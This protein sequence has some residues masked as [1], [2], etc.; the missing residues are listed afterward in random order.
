[1]PLVADRLRGRHARVPGVADCPVAAAALLV[2]MTITEDMQDAILKVPADAWT[3]AYDGDGQVRDGAW[4]ADITGMPDLSSWPGG[5]RVI[6]RK[7]RPPPAAAARPALAPGRP[8]HRCRHPAAGPPV[9]L[10][11]QN[12]HFDQGRSY[13]GP[14]EPRPSARQPGSQPRPAPE[15]HHQPNHSGQYIRHEKDRG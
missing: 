8:G 12:H 4:V 9:R 7:E 2:G 11:S 15:N 6:V 10:T 13:P 1:M 5:M 3:P 14:V